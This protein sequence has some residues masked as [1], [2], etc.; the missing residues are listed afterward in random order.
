MAEIMSGP[1]EPG[2]PPSLTAPA[3]AHAAAPSAIK[4]QIITPF[5]VSGGVD[6]TGKA[7]AIDYDKLIQNFGSK[8]IDA[9]LLER[10]EK[11]TG[12]KP[13]R[14][15]RRGMVFSHRDLDIILDKYEKGTPMFLYTGRGPSSD[16]MHVGHSVPFEFTKYLQE[17]FNIPLVI[18]LTD[19]EKFF[20]TPKL[21]LEDC[22]KFALQNAMDIIAIGFDI[23]KTFMFIDTDFVDNG[24]GAAFN[25]NVR[26]LGKR[27]TINQI[28][29]TFGFGDSNNI[30]EFGFPA[31][32]SATAFATSFPFIF[33][34]DP[35][36]VAKIPCLIP[37]AID[38]DPYFRQCRDNARQLGFI[39]PA[40]IHAVFLPSL[41]GSETK[42]SA[43]D[44]DSSIFL[45]D[46]DKQ[47]Q[48]KIG[49]AFSGGQDSREE[50]RRL[51]GRTDVDIPFQYLR[52]FLEDDE[53]LEVIRE[54]YEKGEM[55]SGEM[56][57]TCT[58]ILQDYVGEFRKR[59]AKVTMEVVEEFL[60]P[61]NLEWKGSQ[62]G[63][64]FKENEVERLEA[65][66]RSL[67]AA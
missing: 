27:T 53:E 57:K 39:K 28:K 32:Q 35:K 56:K 24:Y 3:L 52:F 51:G 5:D 6:E 19:D 18:M 8:K 15:M 16:S 7:V 44:A 23:K 29:G 58:K 33:G 61:R 47:I 66:L 55:E 34:N 37:C 22:H 1:D 2:Q 48:K 60:R 11:V 43:S 36:R 64:E 63:A 9:A 38:Q 62:G 31:M 42:M 46:T 25:K 45:A 49:N 41:R 17:V 10:F 65:R 67:R 12:H 30:A 50:H 20:H 4:E 26:I 40:L 59:R 13:H 54:R 21:S 14:L